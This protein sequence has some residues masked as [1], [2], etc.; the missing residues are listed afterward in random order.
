MRLVLFAHASSSAAPLAFH[1]CGLCRSQSCGRVAVVPV[2]A[3]LA[4]FAA[5]KQGTNWM[6]RTENGKLNSTLSILNSPATAVRAENWWRRGAWEDVRRVEFPPGWVF[7]S[8]E[9]HLTFVD[10]VSQG[11]LRRRWTDTNEIAS[12]GIR[13]A[14]APFS[15]EFRH[16]FT[17]SNS[18][19]F[20]WG[21][22][23]AGR[24]VDAPSTL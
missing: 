5:S 16:E 9:D 18:C 14:L 1:S 10:V 4:N 24:R 15:S 7:P 2:V 20:V 6:M 23:L 3:L 21:G 22:A 11:S 8:G 17:P 12:V 19:R 13:L